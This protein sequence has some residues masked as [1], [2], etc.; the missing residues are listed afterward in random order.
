MN[1]LP[2]ARVR[3]ATTDVARHR[4]VNVVVCRLRLLTQKHG[5][6]HELAGLAVATLRYILLDPRTLQRV[7]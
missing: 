6:T 2:D 4:L 3:P 7:A 5:R 1:C